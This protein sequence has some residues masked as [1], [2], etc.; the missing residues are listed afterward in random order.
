MLFQEME[1][2]QGKRRLSAT[3]RDQSK[4]SSGAYFP[5][6]VE[7]KLGDKKNKFEK[8]DYQAQQV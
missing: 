6:D 7:I 2:L 3:V 8:L 1:A 4:R 5:K